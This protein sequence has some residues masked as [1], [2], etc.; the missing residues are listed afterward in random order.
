MEKVWNTHCSL[1]LGSGLGGEVSWGGQRG[2][3]GK[4][5][6]GLCPPGGD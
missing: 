4:D 3:G 5:E 2:A 6:S 1:S